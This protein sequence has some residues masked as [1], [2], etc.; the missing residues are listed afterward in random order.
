MDETAGIPPQLQ[1]PVAPPASPP[2]IPVPG[3]VQQRPRSGRGW[4]VFAIVL[5]VLL[6]LSVL[7]NIGTF[8]SMV[9]TGG[10]SPVMA[11]RTY[12]PKLE[13]VILEDDHTPNKIAVI[14]LQGIIT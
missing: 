8:A 13:E 14:E 7:F 11:P 3:P 10:R 4:M 9:L 5:L 12:G 6:A 2:P 1:T